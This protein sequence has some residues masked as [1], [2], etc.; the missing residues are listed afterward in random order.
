MEEPITEFAFIE[1]IRPECQ[2]RF[3]YINYEDPKLLSKDSIYC[4]KCGSDTN[5]AARSSPQTHHSPRSLQPASLRVCALVDNIRSAF[6]VGAVFRTADGCHFEHIHLCGITPTPENQR[7][8]KTAL[9]AENIVPWSF[10]PNSIQTAK[11]LRKDGW[12]L[13][14]LENSPHANSIFS[15]TSEE[16]DAPIALIIGNEIAGVDPQLIAM[17]DRILNIPML[18]YKRSLNAAIAFGIAAYHLR[19]SVQR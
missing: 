9:G 4:P 14:C 10:H 8:A 6:N 5:I 18:G 12:L 11:E 16:I 1:C 15:S 3:P 13:L 2:F 19:F 7:V 17:C